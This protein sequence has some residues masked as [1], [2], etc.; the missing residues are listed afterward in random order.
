MI[1]TRC[2]APAP[3]LES[4]A[5]SLGRIMT[6]DPDNAPAAPGGWLE[7]L[8]E[9][10]PRV[11]ARLEDAERRRSSVEYKPT[12]HRLMGLQQL[13]SHLDGVADAVGDGTP[14]EEALARL[15]RRTARDFETAPEAGLSGYLSVA[16]D[17]MR[18]VME[19]T[20]LILLFSADPTLIEQWRV[21]TSE[22]WKSF[23]P[24]AVRRKLMTG[25][26]K[27]TSPQA[28]ADYRGHSAALHVSPIEIPFAP[29][30]IAPEDN[31]MSDAYWWEIFSHGRELVFAL[32]RLRVEAQLDWGSIPHAE[33]LD[34]VKQA[35]EAVIVMQALFLASVE[36][37]PK[38]DDES[39]ETD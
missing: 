33:D 26:V 20:D 38:E 39:A 6:D 15:I 37:V 16:F 24:R 2:L 22:H 32:D 21:W 31:F 35:Y 4:V 7:G 12:G 3:G 11:W 17:S 8:R 18:D 23:A 27:Y 29:R 1:E 5:G 34:D 25:S 28:S 14:A 9:T 30:G 13:L 10:V 19:A 36:E